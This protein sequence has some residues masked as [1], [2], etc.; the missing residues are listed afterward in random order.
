M[1]IIRSRP[2]F[3]RNLDT[4]SRGK[5]FGRSENI[6]KSFVKMSLEGASF[7]SSYFENCEFKDCN[8]WC[9]DF[10]SATFL[11]CSI[12]NCVSFQSDFTNSNIDSLS[13]K[14]NTFTNSNISNAVLKKLSI[15]TS[16]VRFRLVDGSATLK[17]LKSKSSI[18]GLS[19]QESRNSNFFEFENCEFNKSDIE[20]PP[21]HSSFVNQIRFSNVSFKGMPLPNWTWLLPQHVAESH[22]DS[23]RIFKSENI[24]FVVRRQN[25][26]LKFVVQSQHIILNFPDIRISSWCDGS[27]Q[28]LDL[29]QNSS[30]NSGTLKLEAILKENYAGFFQFE[31]GSLFTAAFQLSDLEKL[32]KSYCATDNFPDR[33]R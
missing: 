32:E 18:L 2:D 20:I 7:K 13:L 4:K 8:L 22:G 21:N 14:G 33:N 11:N 26:R 23:T 3:K 25:D 1:A 31:F 15:D 16:L 17:G 28:L 30:A 19:T 10:S 24:Q 12:E 9:T 5:D 27:W 6:G 29:K